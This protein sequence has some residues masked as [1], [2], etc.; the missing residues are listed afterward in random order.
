MAEFDLSTIAA[1]LADLIN[2]DHGPEE[3]SMG[4]T[5]STTSAYSA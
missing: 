4:S 2:D 5:Y 1:H 3:P